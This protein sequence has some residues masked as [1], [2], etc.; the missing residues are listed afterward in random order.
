MT[1]DEL[2]K[3]LEWVPKSYRD[4][5]QVLWIALERIDDDVDGCIFYKPTDCYYNGRIQIVG[6]KAYLF[7]NKELRGDEV[8]CVII[9]E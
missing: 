1:V 9:D 4:N 2:I 5:C 3:Q 6:R 7:G 8:P